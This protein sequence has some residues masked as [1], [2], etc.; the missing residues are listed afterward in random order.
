MFFNSIIDCDEKND[1]FNIFSFFIASFF[2]DSFFFFIDGIHACDDD[3]DFFDDLL[4]FHMTIKFSH[5]FFLDFL[6][7]RFFIF[8]MKVFFQF[9]AMT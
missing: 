1:F 5:V 4:I 6:Y 2:N 9:R 8:V 3:F 7:V